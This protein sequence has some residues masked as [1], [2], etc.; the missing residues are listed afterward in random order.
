MPQKP[1]RSAKGTV[2]RQY[3]VRNSGGHAEAVLREFLRRTEANMFEPLWNVI[4]IAL[5]K[6]LAMTCS[7]S[8]VVAEREKKLP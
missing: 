6:S 4:C 2:C 1:V 8:P 7:Q 5:T 3:N